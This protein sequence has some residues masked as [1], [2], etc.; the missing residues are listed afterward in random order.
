MDTAV[1]ICEE[2]TRFRLQHLTK[3]R[4]QTPEISTNINAPSAEN[5]SFNKEA[6]PPVRKSGSPC[7]EI[8]SL[9]FTRPK[10]KYTPKC[11]L[12]NRQNS[13]WTHRYIRQQSP[14]LLQHDSYIGQGKRIS[15]SRDTAREFIVDNW[16]KLIHEDLQQQQPICCH[17]IDQMKTFSAF[18]A[19]WHLVQ[20]VQCQWK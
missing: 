20:H 9:G 4:W 5:W 17:S 16:A 6:A 3:I 10:F 11:L 13:A 7:I 14:K 19:Q 18:A 1:N 15:A 2:Y 8:W 12:R